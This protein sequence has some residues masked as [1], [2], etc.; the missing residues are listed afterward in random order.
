[1]RIPKSLLVEVLLIIGFTRL[2][3]ADI[4][5]DNSGTWLGGY[6]FTAEEQGDEVYAAGS[7]RFVTKLTIGV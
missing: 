2:A 5:Y 7:A 6:G 3:V 4:I 1:M